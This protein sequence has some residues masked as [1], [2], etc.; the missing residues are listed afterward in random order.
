MDHWAAAADEHGLLTTADLHAAGLNVREITALTQEGQLTSLARGWY[1]VGVLDDAEH[2]HVLTTRAMLRAHEGRAVA[3]HH[4]ALLLLGLP[5]YRADLS[6]IR[7]AR[8]ST[9]SPR[10][11]AA[12]SLGRT[13]PD[14]AILDETVVPALAVVQHGISSGPLSALVAADAALHR[15]LTTP[16]ELTQA[17]TWVH[18]HPKSA[19][20]KGFMAL[21]DGR[22]E[23]PG[24]TRLAHA[25]HLMKVEATPQYEVKAKG[26]SAVVDFLLH[27]E[28][29]VLEFDGQVKYGRAADETDPY[30]RRL[31]PQ[32]VLWLEKQR[33]DRIREL[34]Y[35]VVRVIWSDLDDLVTLARRIAAAVRRTHARRLRRLPA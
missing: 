2:R 15:K 22:R 14:E 23:S 13:V 20:L 24:E 11:R 3:A 1:A 8:R 32:Q 7:L 18:Q 26:F 16:H 35:E 25:L 4:S 34:D 29:V 9:G 30:G 19:P 21:A 27:V 17:L 12:Q 6:R 33:E 31:T 5:T 28:K 10:T